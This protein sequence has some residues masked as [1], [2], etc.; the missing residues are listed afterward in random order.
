MSHQQGGALPVRSRARSP[1]VTMIYIAKRMQDKPNRVQ[2]AV[3]GA[4]DLTYNQ[5]ARGNMPRET[6]GQVVPASSPRSSSSSGSRTCSA[7]SRCR[8]TPSE[9]VDIFGLEL[10]GVRPLRGHREPVGPAG[11]HARRCSSLYQVEGI[12][13]T[14]LVKY[15]KGWLPAGRRRRRRGPDLRHRGD[16]AV[17]PDHLALRPTVRQHPRRPPADPVHGRRARR[18]ARASRRSAGSRCRSRSSSS[19]SRSA[20]WRP[21]RHSSSQRS[22]PSTS[23]RQPPEVTERRSTMDCSN[24]SLAIAAGHDDGRRPQGHR[25]RRRRRPRHRSAPASASATSSER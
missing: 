22:R 23:A 18:A 17:R 14:G 20:W 12:R 15:L 1:T 13:G 24:P 25:A 21:C 11:A 6:R 3:E 10:P 5:I 4:Y 9:T 16:L 2:T 19:S 8:R 7:T